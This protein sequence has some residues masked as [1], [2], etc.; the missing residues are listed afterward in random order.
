MK[1]I[2]IGS[3]G[4]KKD[5]AIKKSSSSGSI[6]SV[7]TNVIKNVVRNDWEVSAKNSNTSIVLLNK[8]SDFMRNEMSMDYEALCMK[9][10]A[11]HAQVMPKEDLRQYVGMLEAL[12]TGYK[13]K[14]GQDSRT[15]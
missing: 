1:A 7:V 6:Y 3:A 4:F 12:Q 15:C 11:A 9:N 2:G 10:I 8:I 5:V 14:Y 13:T